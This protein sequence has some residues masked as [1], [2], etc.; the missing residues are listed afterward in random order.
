MPQEGA[1]Q[2]APVTREHQACFATMAHQV[3]PH[4]AEPMVRRAARLKQ[5]RSWTCGLPHAAP[6]GGPIRL[7]TRLLRELARVDVPRPATTPRRGG[8][9]P[10]VAD[11]FVWPTAQSNPWSPVERRPL[12][13]L[14]QVRVGRAARPRGVENHA[15]P[16]PPSRRVLR[17]ERLR[18]RG[19]STVAA[20]EGASG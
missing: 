1:W 14:V 5:D 10:S 16:S 13:V 20:P 15:S 17:E 11:H 19:A 3:R 18:R 7:P 4:Q 6:T 9:G 2:E 8:G 12:L